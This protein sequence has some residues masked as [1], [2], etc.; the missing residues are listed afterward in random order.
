[1]PAALHAAFEDS[2]EQVTRLFESSIADAEKNGLAEVARM[3]KLGLDSLQQV[4]A[5]VAPGTFFKQAITEN[6]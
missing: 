1:M 2:P 4:P 5:G 3:L 6:S